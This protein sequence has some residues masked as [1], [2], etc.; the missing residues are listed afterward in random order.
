MTTTLPQV[1]AGVQDLILTV[2]GVRLAP[3]S[4]P[5]TVQVFPAVMVYPVSGTVE[6]NAAGFATELH[7]IGV[8]LLVDASDW[9]KSYATGTGLLATILRKIEENPTLSGTVQTYGGLSYTW[10]GQIDLSG[11]PALRWAIQITDVKIQH[12]W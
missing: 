5:N 7:V 10:A 2:P 3:D 8:D 11:I 4:L 9:A 12:T 6:A 1:V